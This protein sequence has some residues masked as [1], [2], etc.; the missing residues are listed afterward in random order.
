M[1]KNGGGYSADNINTMRMVQ[2]ATTTAGTTIATTK[3]E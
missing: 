1:M 2:G 3:G